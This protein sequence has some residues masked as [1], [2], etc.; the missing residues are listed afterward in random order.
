MFRQQ[1]ALLFAVA[2]SAAA[3]TACSS[4][5]SPSAPTSLEA[6]D[7]S[8]AAQTSASGPGSGGDG[9]DGE[10][11]TGV[12]RVRCQRRGTRR[13][14]VS[15]DGNNLPSGTYARVPRLAA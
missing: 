10:V 3:F 6:T 2:V 9:G 11:D 4:T 7:L 12:I 8:G 14:K 1:K 13:S 5:S 15:I